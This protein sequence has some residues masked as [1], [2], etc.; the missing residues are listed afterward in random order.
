MYFMKKI[1]SFDFFRYSQFYDVMILD[2]TE[3]TKRGKVSADLHAGRSPLAIAEFNELPLSFVYQIKRKL[4]A[5]EHPRGRRHHTWKAC[6][7]LQHRQDTRFCGASAED[8]G[9]GTQQVHQVFRMGL[10][11]GL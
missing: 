10:K 7:L 11:A 1:K 9:P 8:G 4:Q 6:P 3:K 5:P 2:L